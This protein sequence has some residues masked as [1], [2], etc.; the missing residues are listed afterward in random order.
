MGAFISGSGTIFGWLQDV[1]LTH[2]HVF[3]ILLG[4]FIKRGQKY[5]EKLLTLVLW[6]I[7]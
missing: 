4:Q 1:L 5:S 7:V 3:V 6:A 2:V